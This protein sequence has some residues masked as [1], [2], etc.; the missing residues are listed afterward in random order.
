MHSVHCGGL[1][2]TVR[3]ENNCQSCPRSFCFHYQHEMPFICQH[4]EYHAFPSC[5]LVEM[6]I[7]ID[8]LACL[9]AFQNFCHSFVSRWW[10]MKAIFLIVPGVI[11]IC[12]QIENPPNNISIW[13]EEQEGMII[14]QVE[15][16][17]RGNTKT[18]K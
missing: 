10:E 18:F 6:E 5:T 2:N 17:Y 15:W 11:Y 7:V 9:H 1:L 4:D 3:Q 16:V 14:H 8:R 13:I 12:F